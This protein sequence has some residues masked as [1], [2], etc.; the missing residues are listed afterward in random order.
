MKKILLLTIALI[1]SAHLFSQSKIEKEA[2]D[3]FWGANDKYKKV[4]E[5][6][7]NW[8]NESAVIIYK[9]ENYDFHKFGK[10]VTYT[11]SI[12]KRIKLLDMAAVEEFSEFSFTKRGV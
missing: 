10:S 12:R 8:K 6:P 1:F 4:T 11:T 9:N 5:I 7:D 3:F 2:Q